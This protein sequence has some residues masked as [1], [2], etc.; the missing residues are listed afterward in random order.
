MRSCD[1][2]QTFRHCVEKELSNPGNDD[3]K[4]ELQNFYYAYFNDLKPECFMVQKGSDKCVEYDFWHTK[5]LSKENTEQ[6]V[7][8]KS[9]S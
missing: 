6:F 5:C 1:C 9:V 3:D 8:R 2:Q 4:Q 7:L